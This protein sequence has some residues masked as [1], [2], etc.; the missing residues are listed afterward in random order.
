M[1]VDKKSGQGNPP[2]IGSDQF[3]QLPNSSD[4]SRYPYEETPEPLHIQ[5]GD[6][7]PGTTGN[8]SLQRVRPVMINT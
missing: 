8:T 4:S 3:S 5:A 7:H 1:E 2:E 6:R